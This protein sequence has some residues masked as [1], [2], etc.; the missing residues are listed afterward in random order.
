MT[1]L[2]VGFLFCFFLLFIPLGVFLAFWVCGLVK[3]I[4]GN[5]QSLLFL[6]FLSLFLLLLVFPLPVSH[7]LLLS[8][9]P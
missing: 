7:L 9:C 8:L 2:D 1:D 5:S 6:L 3:I 4:R